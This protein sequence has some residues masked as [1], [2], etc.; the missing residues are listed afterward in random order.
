MMTDTIT[1]THIHGGRKFES[2][3]YTTR[4][5]RMSVG[6]VD[7]RSQ[8]WPRVTNIIFRDFLDVKNFSSQS[9]S[10]QRTTWKMKIS[11]NKL[12]KTYT[13]RYDETNLKIYLIFFSLRWVNCYGRW[14]LGKKIFWWGDRGQNPCFCPEKWDETGVFPLLYRLGG[15]A[16]R[17]RGA[18]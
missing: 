14:K 3:G 11:R 17:H 2:T 4:L 5:A 1:N 12:K 18:K 15:P 8:S 6:L 13:I 9:A 10:G 16:P 7:P